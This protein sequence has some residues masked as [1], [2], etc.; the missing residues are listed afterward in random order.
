MA[1]KDGTDLININVKNYL[2]ED[3]LFDSGNPIAMMLGGTNGYYFTV[4]DGGYKYHTII[5]TEETF[6]AQNNNT[7]RYIGELMI[8]VEDISGNNPSQNLQGFFE[9]EVNLTR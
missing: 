1:Y 9:F 8:I 7:D 5:R 6:N 2:T 4:T 3:N